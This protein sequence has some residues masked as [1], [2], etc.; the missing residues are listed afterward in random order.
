M[1]LSQAIVLA[2][3]LLY[4]SCT[5]FSV[6][7]EAARSGLRF[8]AAV[9]VD[10]LKQESQY[11]ETLAAN[12]DLMTPEN[13]LKIKATEPEEGKFD[14][15]DADEVLR[16]ASAHHQ[17]VRGHTLV[18]HHSLPSWVT[19]LA[20][21]ERRSALKHHIR[22]VVEHCRKSFPGVVRYWDVVNEAVGDDGKLRAD[23]PW[24]AIGLSAE[25]YIA[26]AFQWAHDADPEAELFYNDYGAEE[27][28]KKSDAVYELVKRM[29]QHGVPIHG[30]GL[31]MHLRLDSPPDLK[32]VEKNI[33]RLAALGLKIHFTEL[34]VAIRLPASDADLERQAKLY[35][36]L[37]NLCLESRVCEAF[38]TWGFTDR[39]SWIPKTFSGFGAA[40]P[41]DEEYAPKPA[42]RA[43]ADRLSR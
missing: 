36:D 22:T 28:S 15:R 16:F 29:K 6:R 21:G 26:E 8:G 27:L 35:G 37:L 2:I 14:F 34:D 40:L 9:A 42:F 7:D 3:P 33:T 19:A 1:K 12:Y 13:A 5:Y 11:R 43:L 41:F 39:Y 32:A 10:P 4:C 31:Q 23:S 24:S 17:L 20:P 18:W 25:S 38:V 30:V